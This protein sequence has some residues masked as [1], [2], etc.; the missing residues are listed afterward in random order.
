M[1]LRHF[2]ADDDLT[3]AEQAA[4]LDLADKLKADP[5]ADRPLAGPRS[6]ALLFDKPTLRT[7]TSFSAGVVELGGYPMVVD[8][9]LAQIGEREPIADVARVL[10]RQCAAIV[11]RT[12]GQERIEEMAA[13]AGVPVINALTDRYHP[14]QA[15]ADLMTVREHR[16]RLAGLTF[17]Y[18]GDGAN[19][20]AHSYL[21]AGALAGLH[22]RVGA[23]AGF[24]PDPEL[25]ARAETLAS[26]SGGSVLVSE[27]ATEAVAG[28]DVVATDTWVSMG[29]E[30][31][32][33]DRLTP[34]APYAV[35][36]DL[37][38][39]A[40]EAIVVHCLP[41]HRG[42]EIAAEV[43]DGPRAVIWDEAENRRHVQKALLAFLLDAQEATP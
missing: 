20:V 33:R 42:A 12:S 25:L 10:G 14:C 26:A 41:A 27:S 34:F 7:Q 31:D 36:A 8:G 23:P 1:T 24:Q 9:R 16:G 3:A 32:G 43:L 28:A 29:T 21:L 18:V 6:V 13:Y 40:P 30:D 37:L 22:L 15:L 4:V 39:G 5:Y 11:W 19:N 17:A 35:T 38:A 2:L